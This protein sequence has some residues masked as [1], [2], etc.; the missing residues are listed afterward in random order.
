MSPASARTIQAGTNSFSQADSGSGEALTIDPTGGT[1]GAVY[2]ITKADGT[3]VGLGLSQANV[4]I[5]ASIDLPGGV[6]L[7][8]TPK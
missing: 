4:L 2:S 5:Y 8:C 7:L 6:H 3:G 1:A